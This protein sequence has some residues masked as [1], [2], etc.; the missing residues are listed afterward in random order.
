MTDGQNIL[1]HYCRALIFAGNTCYLW[2]EAADLKKRLLCECQL[3]EGQRV[4]M[5]GTFLNGSGLGPA[6][7]SVV[8]E[9]N[10][11]LIDLSQKAIESL[12]IMPKAQ[13][14]WELDVFDSLGVESFD[15]VIL[16]G[17][18]SHILNWDACAEKIASILRMQ[19]R[20]V[21][22]ENQI[23]GKAFIN[24]CHEDARLE[25]LHIRILDGLGLREDE[26]PDVDPAFLEKRFAKYLT[27]S[28]SD[29]Q[30]GLYVF[31]GQKGADDKNR[32]QEWAPT[33]EMGAFLA[34]NPLVS[35]WE[36]LRPHELKAWGDIAN[37]AATLRQAQD[38]FLDGWLRLAYDRNPDIDA[39]M[40]DKNSIAGL[41][42]SGLL[43][44]IIEKLNF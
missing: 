15:R 44:C 5:V 6:V 37:D 14:Q 32:K 18:A 29:A 20:V 27:W 3:Q 30:G 39:G 21:I 9:S 1:A 23:G 8:G 10:A 43:K 11:T 2:N 35:P 36:L 17:V 41:N 42:E 40:K 28:S 7:K 31:C 24:A 33:R 25:A 13:L 4:L 12:Q 38:L 16:F 26:W 19:G 34:E 22:A